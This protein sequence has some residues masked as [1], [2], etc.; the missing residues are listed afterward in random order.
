[1]KTVLRYRVHLLEPT[2]V[3]ALQGDPNE[4]VAFD[5]LPGSVLRGVIIGQYLRHHG[6]PRLHKGEETT[7]FLSNQ[8]RYLNAYPLISGKRACPTPRSWIRRSDGIIDRLFNQDTSP[9][10]PQRIRA[11]FQV[12][13]GQIVACYDVTRHINVHI[14]R[15]RKGMPTGRRAQVNGTVEGGTLYRYDSLA[16]GQVF[17]GLI[18][19]EDSTAAEV[20]EPLLTGQR[21]IGGARTASYGLTDWSLRESTSGDDWMEVPYLQPGHNCLLLA[22]PALLRDPIHGQYSVDQDT[23]RW[24][25][26]R[27][28]GVSVDDVSIESCELEY[29]MVGGFNRTWGMPLPQALAV[30]AGSVLK[31]NLAKE[32]DYDAL[33]WYG[34]GERRGEG[35]GRVVLYEQ[36]TNPLQEQASPVVEKI[37]SPELT[38]YAAQLASDI[39]RRIHQERQISSIRAEALKRYQIQNP[40]NN[41]QL[42]ALRQKVQEAIQRDQPAIVTEFLQNA[43]RPS[44]KQF[45]M[46]SIDG[47]TLWDWLNEQIQESPASVT[48]DQTNDVYSIANRLK[49][50]D[51]VLAHQVRQ[52]ER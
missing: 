41:T 26:A 10:K 36:G 25:I 47:R 51:A 17:E 50:I 14:E 22:S 5:Y 39:K 7:W 28:L 48:K 1:M 42:N 49:L 18:L 46:S 15:D 21:R 13:D 37:D 11:P 31:I 16:A 38:G 29:E 34:I 45:E 2:L 30:R 19:C 9:S 24:H 6:K 40:P 4:A 12:N 44:R 35:F 32:F 52:M 27:R 43:S 8:V 20:I 3:T 23:L 33:L